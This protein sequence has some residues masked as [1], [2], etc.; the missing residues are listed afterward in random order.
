LREVLAKE[1]EGWSLHKEPYIGLLE[2]G[3]FSTVVGF[4]KNKCV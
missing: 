2:I 3:I 1:I 4:Y